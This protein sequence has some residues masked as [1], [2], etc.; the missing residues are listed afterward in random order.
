MVLGQH[1]GS[2]TCGAVRVPAA[3]ALIMLLLAPPR[4]RWLHEAP[5]H[6]VQAHRLPAH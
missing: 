1:G 3:L 5:E 4:H 6:P 2:P